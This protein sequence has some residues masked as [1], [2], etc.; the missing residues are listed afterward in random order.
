MARKE[1]EGGGVGAK[2]S[3]NDCDGGMER[4]WLDQQCSVTNIYKL[5]IKIKRRARVLPTKLP[6][7]LLLLLLLILL[8]LPRI[9]Y[10]LG[11]L[12]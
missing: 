3:M 8:L 7:F 6:L 4:A 11:S 10:S 12:V 5:I 1:L 2:T 9:L